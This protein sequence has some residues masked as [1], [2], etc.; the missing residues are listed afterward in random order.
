MKYWRLLIQRRDTT[1]S[2]ADQIHI[3]P[4]LLAHYIETLGT[5][6]S[7]AGGGI[8]R[9]VYSPT[10]QEARRQLAAWMAEAGLEVREDA[11]GNLFGRLRGSD[12][13]HTILTGS[14]IDTVKLGGKYD[15]ALGVLSALA[16]LRALREQVGQPRQSLE[17]VALCEEEGSRFQAH[18]WGSRGMWGMIQPQELEALRDDEGFTIAQAMQAAGFPPERYREAVRSD[19]AAFLEL[20]IEQGRIL[21]DEHINIGIVEAIAGMQRQLITV[22][23][24][25]DHAGTT[26]MDLRRDA[27]QGAASMALEITR[28]VEQEGRPAVVTMG[29]WDVR[30]GA[31]NIVPGW[32]RFSIDLRHPD[33][34]AL[35]R[36]SQAILAICERIANERGLVISREIV[37]DSAPMRMNRDLQNILIAAA[38]TC[39]ATWKYL[40]SGAGHDSEVMAHHVPTAMLFVPSVEG[41]SHSPAEYTSLEDAVHGATVLAVALYKLAY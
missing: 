28:M 2:E 9:P 3:D 20:H 4:A 21:Y 14:H 38:E 1:M 6:G 29:K 22:E 16:T 13:T 12:D 31:F 27:F 33:E 11:V 15:G 18:Y 10:W 35:Q 30:P 7:Q 39:R 5:I 26:P 24:R 25:A 32:V 37:D 19:V 40:P 8:I 34:A 23:G 41:R 36:L 17:V